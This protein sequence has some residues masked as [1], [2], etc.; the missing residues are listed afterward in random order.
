MIKKLNNMK[1]LYKILMI[2]FIF[3]ISITFFSCSQKS[4]ASYNYNVG[5]KS[6]TTI[7]P[8]S[9]KSQPVRK[10]FVIHNKKRNILGHKKPL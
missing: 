3:S 8:V 2:V 1:G 10:K 7:D 4:T 9:T 6:Q 5:K